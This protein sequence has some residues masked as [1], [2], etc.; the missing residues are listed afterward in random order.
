MSNIFGLFVL[1]LVQ[2]L[3]M[4]TKLASH[5]RPSASG[6]G[7]LDVQHS[8]ILLAFNPLSA[9]ELLSLFLK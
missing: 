4:L 1:L 3:L 5:L 9:L 6:A 7:T 2:G 8:A